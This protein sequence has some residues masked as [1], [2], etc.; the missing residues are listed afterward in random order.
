MEY[1]LAVKAQ[2]PLIDLSQQSKKT[3]IFRLCHVPIWDQVHPVN[4][5]PVN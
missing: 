3:A 4:R 5:P 1:V 2:S